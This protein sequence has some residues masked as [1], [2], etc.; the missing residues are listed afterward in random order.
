MRPATRNPNTFFIPSF[1]FTK[2]LA[3]E[4]LLDEI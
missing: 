1:I 4:V 3:F 2:Y